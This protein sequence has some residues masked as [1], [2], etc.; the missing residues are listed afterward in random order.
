MSQKLGK[1]SVH[2]T[3][4][5]GAFSRVRYCVDT[6]TNNAFALKVIDRKRIIDEG[7]E[8]SLTNEIT[9]MKMFNHRS[10]VAV[11]DMLASPNRIFLVLDLMTDGNMRKKLSQER[12]LNEKDAIFY[13]KQFFA[14]VEYL[15]ENGI[16][17][18]NLRLENLLLH[19]NGNLRITDFR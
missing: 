14:G 5:K 8:E 9:L 1:Y 3:I 11:K 7:M 2:E 12:Y 13:F 18:G 4:G 6:N 15:H 10:V 17:H 19:T 16:T